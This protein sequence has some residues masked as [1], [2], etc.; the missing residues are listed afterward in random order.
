LCS[1]GPTSSASYTGVLGL[2][3]DFAVMLG[4]TAALVLLAARPYPRLIQ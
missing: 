4:V 1:K 2:G 3:V